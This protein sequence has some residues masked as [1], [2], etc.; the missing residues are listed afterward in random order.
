MSWLKILV[1]SL[2]LCLTIAEVIDYSGFS[3]FDSPTVVFRQK[4]ETEE[5]RWLPTLPPDYDLDDSENDPKNVTT[6]HIYYNMTA[7]SG[8]MTAFTDHY[9]NMTQFLTQK[10]VTGNFTHEHLMK[11]YRKAAGVKLKF[12]FPFYGHELT[13]VTIATGG[14]LYVGDQTHSWLA[15][16]QYIAPLMANFDTTSNNSMITF[17]DD[18]SRFIVEWSNVKLRD[19]P[20]AGPFTFQLSLF[21]NGDIWFVYKDIP[22]PVANISDVNHPCKLGVSDAY[23]FNHKMKIPTDA[24][25]TSSKRVIHEYHRISLNGKEVVSNAVVILKALPTCHGFSDCESCSNSSL[26]FFSCTWCVPSEEESGFCSDLD[27]L[28]RKR[29]DFVEGYCSRPKDK[30]CENPSKSSSKPSGSSNSTEAP[31][32]DAVVSL[33]TESPKTKSE[34]DSGKATLTYGK[35]FVYLSILFI[36]VFVAWLYYAYNNPYSWSG[37]QL[38]KYRPSKWRSPANQVRYSA[39]GHM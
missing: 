7:V 8:D 2:A 31:H 18:G 17:G 10:N 15:A 34:M 19:D 11:A 6:E 39:S 14:F 5:T 12:N 30:V 16:T 38:I 22:I 4:R 33:S 29:Q 13:N 3:S 20:N 23:L 28:H 24:T 9:M 25:Q 35:T 37:Q 26:K 1:S 32:P 36:F 27:G 21:S